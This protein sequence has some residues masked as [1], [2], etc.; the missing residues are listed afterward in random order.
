MT[1]EFVVLTSSAIDDVD[2]EIAG[3]A[4]TFPQDCPRSWIGGRHLAG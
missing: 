4:R 1:P 2:C 3:L